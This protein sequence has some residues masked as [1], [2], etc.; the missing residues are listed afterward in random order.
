VSGSATRRSPGPGDL[1]GLVPAEITPHGRRA[2]DVSPCLLVAELQTRGRGRLGR[3]W[4]SSAGASLTFSCRCRWR[5]PTGRACRWPW[6][7]RWPK[8]WTRCR[9]RC[10]QPR[11]GLK[12]PNDL[13]L[14]DDGGPPAQPAASWAAS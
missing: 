4:V 10:P 2:G 3:G 11:I 14:L 5:R 6:A 1:D 9:W 13:W 12:W 7:W 8:R